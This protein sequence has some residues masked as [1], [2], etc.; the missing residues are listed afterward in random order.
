MYMERTHVEPDR[1]EWDEE[2][3]HTRFANVYGLAEYLLIDVAKMDPSSPHA[4]NTPKRFV[5][6]L[7]ELT[8]PDKFEFT[9]FPATSRDMVVIKQVPVI[10]VC[11]HHIIPFRGYAQVGYIPEQTVAGLSKIPRLVKALSKGLSVQEE[12]TAEIA[13]QLTKHLG[14]EHVAVV[15]ECEHLC[16]TIRG[17]QAPGT[18]TYTAT[19]RGHFG[20]HD[21]TAKD[22]FLRAIGK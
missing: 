7:R 19:M 17:V 3:A 16:M 10:S 6:M 20:E 14:T 21:R 18:T 11:A 15:M 4:K 22:E 2:L 12:L 13:E 5:Q 1:D 8:T 9:T